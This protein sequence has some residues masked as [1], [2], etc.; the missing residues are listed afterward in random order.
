M[1]HVYAYPSRSPSRRR[2][3]AGRWP[4]TSA[5]LRWYTVAIIASAMLD[6]SRRGQAQVASPHA[7][8]PIAAA[9][10]RPRCG[11]CH[12]TGDAREGEDGRP[13]A[14]NIRRGVDG[15]GPPAMRCG[16][17]HQDVSSLTPHAPPGAPDWRLPPAATPMAW[18]GLAAGDQCRMLKDKT[19]N[20]GRTL[21]DLLDHMS[22]DPLVVA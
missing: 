10:S 7:F 11:D 18:K 9:L 4:M 2:I 21:A 13:L 1:W 22:H 8:E 5:R 15:R 17:C 6:A 14:S 20:G 16:N 12:I 19:K 3:D